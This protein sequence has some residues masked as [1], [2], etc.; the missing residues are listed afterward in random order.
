MTLVL[1]SRARTRAAAAPALRR[2]AAGAPLPPHEP[3]FDEPGV[4]TVFK[5][6]FEPYCELRLSARG[7]AFGAELLAAY[8]TRAPRRGAALELGPGRRAG[9]GARAR[10]PRAAA[11]AAPPRDGDDPRFAPFASD[12]A[13]ATRSAARCRTAAPTRR[14]SA[15]AI[16]AGERG[17][18]ACSAPAPYGRLSTY[19]IALLRGDAL[20]SAHGTASASA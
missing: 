10:P 8:E 3:S 13:L 20:A 15:C 18:A 6:F 16:S 4:S 9:G 11:A 2:D 5:R 12:D 19:A 17:R 7:D 14:S 1:A